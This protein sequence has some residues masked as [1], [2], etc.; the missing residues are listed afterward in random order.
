[1]KRGGFTL[2]EVLIAVLILVLAIASILPLFAIGTTSHKRG[3]DQSHVAW[4]APRIAAKLQENL[5]RTNPQNITG[6]AWQEYGAT[7]L[8]DATFTP[9][10]AATGGDPVADA[11][12]LL[13]VSVRWGE[14]GAARS[15]VFE[16]VVLRKLLR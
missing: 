2:L 11:A 1:M 7:Y 14:A 5:T 16:M 15:E 10:S 12:F 13:K 9:L 8:Y 4:I 6:G 3:M